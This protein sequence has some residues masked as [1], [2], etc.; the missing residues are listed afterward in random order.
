MLCRLES[1]KISCIQYAISVKENV[2]YIVFEMCYLNN[3]FRDSWRIE[4]LNTNATRVT[5]YWTYK[6]RAYSGMWVKLQRHLQAFLSSQEVSFMPMYSTYGNTWMMLWSMILSNHLY[7]KGLCFH[8]TKR[9]CKIVQI[10]PTKLSFELLW[11]L[12]YI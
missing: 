6:E 7:F 12:T 4:W 9:A 5:L 11:K 8:L 3:L 2:L 10:W 1:I